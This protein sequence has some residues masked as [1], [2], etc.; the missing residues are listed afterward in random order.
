MANQQQNLQTSNWILSTWRSS[1]D[2]D[3]PPPFVGELPT[4][5]MTWF[6]KG[7]KNGWL[8]VLLQKID[9][10]KWFLMQLRKSGIFTKK[11]KRGCSRFQMNV[12]TQQ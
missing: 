8:V 6:A 7:D 11:Q 3:S 9:V 1:I 12:I 10:D 2:F 5:K 4:E